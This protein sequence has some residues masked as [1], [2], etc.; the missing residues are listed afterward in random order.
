MALSLES[1]HENSHNRAWLGSAGMGALRVALLF[2][3]V[4]IALALILT[5][6]MERRMDRAAYR[7]AG[8]DSFTTGSISDA[9][10]RHA[11][12]KRRSVLQ[13]SPQALCI[14]SADGSRSGE[15]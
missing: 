8:V 4:G 7:G 11:Y 3:S 15:C 13:S 1:L 10:R 2:G 12:I 9:Q 14:I 5:P 6:L